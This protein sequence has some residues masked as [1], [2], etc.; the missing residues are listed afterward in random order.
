[1][2]VEILSSLLTYL[3]EKNGDYLFFLVLCLTLGIYAF[4]YFL[5]SSK[6]RSEIGVS[7]DDKNHAIARIS[8]L[9]NIDELNF[10]IES[11]QDVSLEAFNV[12]AKLEKIGL[13]PNISTYNNLI[14]M[15]FR[16]R[17]FESAHR[18]FGL[19]TNE[20]YPI[21]QPNVETYTIYLKNVLNLEILPLYQEVETI[22][23]KY[24]INRGLGFFSNGPHSQK[25][26]RNFA[27]NEIQIKLLK[28]LKIISNLA[29]DIS[30]SKTMEF[31]N[32]ILE[33][34]SIFM[35]MAIPLGNFGRNASSCLLKYK[36]IPQSSLNYN[37]LILQISKLKSH[38][39]E[40]YLYNDKSK[41]FKMNNINYVL[42]ES[43]N[44]ELK[45][46]SVLKDYG[47]FAET[48]IENLLLEIEFVYNDNAELIMRK[49]FY[50]QMKKDSLTYFIICK[51]LSWFIDN[52]MVRNNISVSRKV[53]DNKSAI[54]SILSEILMRYNLNKSHYKDIFY[55]KNLAYILKSLYILKCNNNEIQNE[56]IEKY[57]EF[58]H[59][60][61]KNLGLENSKFLI[62]KQ[63][64]M[65]NNSS[66]LSKAFEL[67]YNH[68][69][70][71]N[72]DV[73]VF[74]SILSTCISNISDC[75]TPRNQCKPTDIS[76]EVKNQDHQI[77]NYLIGGNSNFASTNNS[78]EN[79]QTFLKIFEN[80]KNK[81]LKNSLL[82]PST[83]SY[84]LYIKGLSISNLQEELKAVY[85]QMK[86]NNSR[87]F[88]Q[89]TFNYL[90]ENCKKTNDCIASISILKHMEE[91]EISKNQWMFS[92]LIVMYTALNSEEK[93]LESFDEMI[94]S[95]IRPNIETYNSL[96]GIF[97]KKKKILNALG[98][99]QDIKQ[100][101]FLIEDLSLVELLVSSCISSNKI[102]KAIEIVEYLYK[103]SE[104]ESRTKQNQLYYIVL[105]SLLN[106]KCGL[107]FTEKVYYSNQIMKIMKEK[108]IE[109]SDEI[110][111]KVGKMIYSNHGITSSL[112][113]ANSQ[114]ANNSQNVSKISIQTNE[115]LNGGS[116][117]RNN[118][119]YQN[120][121]HSRYS[122]SN[123]SSQ[124]KKNTR[125]G[126]NNNRSNRYSN[127]KRNSDDL[128]IRSKEK[129][130]EENNQKIIQDDQDL[131]SLNNEES[132]N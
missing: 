77:C 102:E 101:N 80:F 71:E 65:Y 17:Q 87:H 37:D 35:F 59:S 98:I 6:E 31:N 108:N 62:C 36:N 88:N 38:F 29:E 79:I 43:M 124:S 16:L 22:Q 132:S 14:E 84:A 120:Y 7:L 51:N 32:D 105:E 2:K 40:Q 44:L 82:E 52:N 95:N 118:E 121:Y 50:D 96:I 9:K 69:K 125:N 54:V 119:Q 11:T 89:L 55:D 13:F 90:I 85:E 103:K 122:Q 99:F 45:I 129:K 41:S 94:K 76:D 130:L 15:S 97:L 113:N 26:N 63:I 73:M 23:M 70:L 60:L 74:N 92:Q 1:M 109:I 91:L 116:I 83:L 117:E 128:K 28:N 61:I 10:L 46:L 115:K 57:Y 64:E 21:Q 81:S 12:L 114:Q 47:L 20:S 19:L 24:G 110:L 131:K 42:Y 56:D 78:I 53:V 75:E 104:L 68:N 8:C 18:L 3:C 66:K 127:R 58:T 123:Y 106:T 112:S 33:I 30:L 49:S 111:L 86:K 48:L 67:Y 126:F 25:F 4:K 34:I 5:K 93:V 39:N 100:N 72:I 27:L 107:K